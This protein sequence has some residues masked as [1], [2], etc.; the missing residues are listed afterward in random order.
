MKNKNTII[1]TEEMINSDPYGYTYKEICDCV[2]EKK[3]RSLMHAL[4]KEKPQK[5]YQTMSINDIYNGGD[6]RKYSF[7]L[8]DGYCVETVCIKRKTGVTVCVSTMVGCPVGCIFCASGSNGFI[9]NLTPSEIVQQVTLLKE[10]VNRI[11]SRM[12]LHSCCEMRVMQCM[13]Y[14][15]CA[16]LQSC[17]RLYQMGD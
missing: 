2:G 17:R 10:K 14:F 9:R 7:K 12:P 11:V 8:K 13:T 3:A 6:T 5:K 1:I 16:S 4:Y 15:F